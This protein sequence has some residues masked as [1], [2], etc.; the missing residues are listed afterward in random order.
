MARTGETGESAW[1]TSLSWPCVSGT[2]ERVATDSGSGY[3]A[4]EPSAPANTP[5]SG[6]TS[7]PAQLLFG[8]LAG[9]GS[10]WFLCAVKSGWFAGRGYRGMSYARTVAAISVV[11]IASVVIVALIGQHLNG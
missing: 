8:G 4:A 6:S 7:R 2:K 5:W 1:T 10:F 3:S 11:F 9:G